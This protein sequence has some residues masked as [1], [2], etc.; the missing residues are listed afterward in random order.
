MPHCDEEKSDLI[1]ETAGS[2]HALSLV[3]MTV[4]GRGR[5][6]R[7][8]KAQRFFIPLRYIQNDTSAALGQ[9]EMSERVPEKFYAVKVFGKEEKPI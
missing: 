4:L 8:A 2:L 6:T 3:E 9:G 1:A 5:K 7:S